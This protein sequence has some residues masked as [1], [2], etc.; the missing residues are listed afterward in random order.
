MLSKMA[1]FAQSLMFAFATM[2]WIS[3]SA[4]AKCRTGTVAIESR[5]PSGFSERDGWLYDAKKLREVAFLAA[6]ANGLPNETERYL[7]SQGDQSCRHVYIAKFT[8]H[9]QFIA[10][11][12]NEL[13]IAAAYFSRLCT[14]YKINQRKLAELT[15]YFEVLPIFDGYNGVDKVRPISKSSKKMYG[16]YW[17]KKNSTKPQFC[18]TTYRERF[19]YVYIFG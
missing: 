17:M 7:K 19:H 5:H 6:L 11:A 16:A 18:K 8:S 10:D 15:Y 12:Y 14:A 9:G 13:V 4:S 2:F 1:L 3:G